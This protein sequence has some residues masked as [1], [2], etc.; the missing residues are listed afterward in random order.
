MYKMPG[1]G[2]GAAGGSV[3]ALAATGADFGWWLAAG[4]FLCVLGVLMVIAAYRRNRRA[5]HR[6]VQP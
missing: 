4:A 1:A 6:D 5:C 2:L 3:G